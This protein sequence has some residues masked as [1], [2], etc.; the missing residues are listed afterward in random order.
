MYEPRATTA[1]FSR[2][3]IAAE[4]TEV[5]PE[6]T[7]DVPGALSLLIMTQIKCMAGVE[8]EEFDQS[9][10]HQELHCRKLDVSRIQD[11]ELYP[12]WMEKV[13]SYEV[14]TDEENWP[15]KSVPWKPRGVATFTSESNMAA[16]VHQDRG[17]TE[18]MQSTVDQTDVEM[19]RE[20][21]GQMMSTECQGSV[22]I[23]LQEV[24]AVYRSRTAGADTT[25][26]PRID[27]DRNGV[28]S[29][30]TL[31]ETNCGGTAGVEVNLDQ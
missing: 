29:L 17:L 3:S 8:D 24:S 26:V 21:H 5:V 9:E 12:S 7:P 18:P 31:T 13:S 16:G 11:V 1:V 4:G 22:G 27:E 20:D 10:S 15:S 2:S 25:A 30:L 28:P 23:E 14:P 19:A 6:L